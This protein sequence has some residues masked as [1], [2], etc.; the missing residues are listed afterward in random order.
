LC[1]QYWQTTIV[2]AQDRGDFTG[3]YDFTFQSACQ[4][5]VTA[6]GDYCS[7]HPYNV[8][9]HLKTSNYCGYLTPL[10]IGLTG[11][12]KTYSDPTVLNADSTFALGDTLYAKLQIDAGQAT[13]TDVTIDTVILQPIDSA[14]VTLASNGVISSAGSSIG[15]VLNNDYAVRTA[16]LSFTL[17]TTYFPLAPQTSTIATIHVIGLVTFANTQTRRLLMLEGSLPSFQPS[18]KLHHLSQM[19][20]S[21]NGGNALALRQMKNVANAEGV[22]L[23]DSALLKLLLKQRMGVQLPSQ[24]LILLKV[25]DSRSSGVKANTPFIIERKENKS[26]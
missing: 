4:N 25:D 8:T 3:E 19:T 7:P 21:I 22:D 9:V 23:A 6:E 14:S 12:L 11:S 24:D 5:S 2:P 10:A 15:L 26:S 20:K 16:T 18:S 13:I 1:V 17:S